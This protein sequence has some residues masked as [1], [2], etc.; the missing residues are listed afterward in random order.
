M[1]EKNKIYE[2]HVYKPLAQ[3]F[4]D[5]GLEVDIED[6]A[7]DETLKLWRMDDA[8]GKL[9]AAAQLVYR[10]GHYVLDNIAVAEEARGKGY[11]EALLQTVETEAKKRG[12][13]E[14]WLVGK[15]PSF[16]ARYGWDSVEKEDAPPIS[17]CQGC[18]QFGISCHPQ[19]MKKEFPADA[20]GR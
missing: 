20:S 14:I 19:I 15:V 12:A 4:D 9:L 10:A 3:L 5:S 2:T 1:T 8:D 11:G 18:S 7:A 17:H 6:E 13:K 16:Y